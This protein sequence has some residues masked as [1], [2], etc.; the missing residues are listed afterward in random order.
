MQLLERRQLRR[1]FSKGCATSKRGS[2]HKSSTTSRKL[3]TGLPSVLEKSVSVSSVTSMNRK[4]VFVA[5]LRS[6]EVGLSSRQLRNGP[7]I[8]RWSTWP[9]ETVRQPMIGPITS[10]RGQ[11]GLRTRSEC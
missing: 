8:N 10:K 5:T 3:K 7:M 2:K 6:K 9:R 4:T 11:I 1:K